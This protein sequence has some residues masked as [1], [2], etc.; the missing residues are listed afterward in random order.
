MQLQQPYLQRI[1]HL[2]RTLVDH[3]SL[4]FKSALKE[5]SIDVLANFNKITLQMTFYSLKMFD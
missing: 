5:L 3:Q 1:L 2:P 4:T